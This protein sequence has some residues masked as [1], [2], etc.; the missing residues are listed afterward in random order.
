VFQSYTYKYVDYDQSVH[1]HCYEITIVDPDFGEETA[2]AVAAV[3]AEAGAAARVAA[4]AVGVIKCYSSKD[5]SVNQ[6]AKNLWLLFEF[7]YRQQS[8][9]TINRQIEWCLKYVPEYLPYHADIQ[10]LMLFS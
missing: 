9:W 3:A 4:A 5:Y 7:N 1:Q 2:V 10:M 8:W 6:I